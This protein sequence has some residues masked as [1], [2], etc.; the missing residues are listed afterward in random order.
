MVLA[1]LTFLLLALTL[2]ASF[3]I[4]HAVHERIRIQAAADAHAFSVAT[5]EARGFNTLAY[6]NRSIAGAI[7]AEM[8]LHAWR[9]ITW[10]DRAM[11][12]A[13][14]VSFLMV[15]ALEFAQCPPYNFQHCVHGFQ[16]LRIAAKYFKQ[17]RQTK[18]DIESKDSQWKQAVKGFS[19]MIKEIA[20]DEKDLMKKVNDQIANSSMVL[21]GIDSKNSP[22]GSSKNLDALNQGI[23]GCA[24]E[25]VSDVKCDNP[26]WRAGVGTESDTNKRMQIMESAAM[27]ARP[28]FQNGRMSARNLSGDGYRTV[29]VIPGPE[30]PLDIPIPAINPDK[31]MDIQGNEG[32]YI[33]LGFTA[34]NTRVSNNRITSSVPTAMVFV[35]WKD[36]FGMFMTSGSQNDS[37]GQYEGVCSDD[38]NCFVNFRM[39]SAPNDADD[40]DYGMPSTYGAFQQDLRT[41][42][43]GG[44]GAW[45]I[46]GKGEVQMPGGTGKFKYVSDNQ[47]YAVAKGKTY[48]HQLGSWEA[49]PNFF[50]PFW[51]A[52]LHPFGRDELQDVLGRIGDTK[53]QQIISGG[54]AVEGD[55]NK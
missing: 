19:D 42:K 7:V 18:N 32:T 47:A 8:G 25:G 40:A 43:N 17:A 16:A 3:S 21:M 38:S 34:Q 36:G 20:E 33:E 51:R 46:E 44:K 29:P 37:M 12:T 15:A 35:Q 23:F 50:D 5:L 24:L 30:E 13:G 1:A 28:I 26:D 9:A 53:G 49:P 52:K 6:L 31:M 39:G 55:V 11:Y 14:G 22:Q 45:E 54:G 41:L 27:A 2:M 10:R 4:S 48:F